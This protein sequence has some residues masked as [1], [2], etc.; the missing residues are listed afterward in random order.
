MRPV[1]ARI[2]GTVTEVLLESQPTGERQLVDPALEAEDRLE[3]AL[4]LEHAGAL[5]RRQRLRELADVV[6]EPEATDLGVEDPGRHE[7]ERASG[8]GEIECSRR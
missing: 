3:G 8:H 2:E 7:V 6:D 1:D 5:H 4:L